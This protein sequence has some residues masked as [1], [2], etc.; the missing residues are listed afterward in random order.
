MDD[1]RSIKGNIGKLFVHDFSLV[2]WSKSSRPR[3]EP[4]KFYEYLNFS[5]IMYG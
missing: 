5:Y 2:T 3:L 1:V 4:L